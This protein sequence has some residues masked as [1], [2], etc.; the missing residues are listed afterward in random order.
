MSMEDDQRLRHLARKTAVKNLE[1]LKACNVVVERMDFI[2]KEFQCSAKI[3][4]TIIRSEEFKRKYCIWKTTNVR[5]LNLKE[6]KQKK[7]AKENTLLDFCLSKGLLKQK[8]S[9]ETSLETILKK[10]ENRVKEI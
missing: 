2:T 1:I 5:F 8:E 4:E 6:S 10:K 7:T 3:K 9:W